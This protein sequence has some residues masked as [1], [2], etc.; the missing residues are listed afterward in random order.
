MKGL[1][2]ADSTARD[3]V[4]WLV[5]ICAIL[6]AVI[7][8]LVGHITTA[9]GMSDA[10]NAAVREMRREYV[11]RTEL[12]VRLDAIN[13]TMADLKVELTELRKSRERGGK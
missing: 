6:I 10:T 5:G 12:Q 8:A 4:G 3:L 11:P 9:Q 7:G 13:E 2:M 1:P